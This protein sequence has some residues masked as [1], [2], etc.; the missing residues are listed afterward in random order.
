M[1]GTRYSHVRR[2]RCLTWHQGGA[3][4]LSGT[5][6]L[7]KVMAEIPEMP[8]E[9]PLADEAVVIAEATTSAH[10]GET[11][12]RGET[13]HIP[14]TAKE[15]MPVID[16]HAPHGGVHTWKDFW[17]HLGTITLGLLIAISLEQSVE[18]AHHLR[19]RH[20][21]EADLQ[22]EGGGEPCACGGRLAGDGRSH[23]GNRRAAARGGVRFG[24]AE[25]D[26]STFSRVVI[27]AANLKQRFCSPFVGRLDDG[28]GRRIDR[29]A[30]ARGCPELYASVLSG[31]P[32]T[33]ACVRLGC[34]GK[35]S[36]RV[37]VQIQ[38]WNA[39]LQ[40]GPLADVGRA[41]R[42]I[43]GVADPVLHPSAS[44]KGEGVDL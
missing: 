35:R 8:E 18:W 41:A 6:P 39:A 44:G 30:S 2:W 36:H 3:D 11:P 26:G 29:P 13:A 25:E 5:G 32:S 23:G 37:R 31:R 19:Q 14:E 12:E 20:Q 28:E 15:E 33:A 7:G 21:L 34:G 22:A 9:L 43:L 16:V 10:R 27:H 4:S 1:W 40:A 24:R 42:G 38:R 17:I